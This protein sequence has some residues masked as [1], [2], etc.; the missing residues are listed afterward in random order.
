M[1]KKFRLQSVLKHRK[2]MEDRS[3]QHLADSLRQEQS[4]RSAL[5]QHRDHYQNLNSLLENQQQ[6]GIAAA[7]LW[8]FV[9][10]LENQRSE[11]RK[12]EAKVDALEKKTVNRLENLQAVSLE[13]QLLDNLK[14]KYLQDQYLEGKRKDALL[15]DELALKKVREDL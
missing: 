9:T 10:R 4:A 12:L 8:L 6:K 3:R 7:D 11:L 1:T 2:L 14:E 13:R 5:D 15:M